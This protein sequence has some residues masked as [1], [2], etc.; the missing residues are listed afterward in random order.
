LLDL[1]RF[2][3][4]RAFRKTTGRTPHQWLLNLRLARARRLLAETSLSVTDVALT[5]GYQTPSAFTHAFRSC[6]GLTPRELR[7]RL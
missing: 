5:V 7:R 1:S 6:F 2:Y 4:C 3:F